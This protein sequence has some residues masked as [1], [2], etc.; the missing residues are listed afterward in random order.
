MTELYTIREVLYQFVVDEK[1][2][3]FIEVRYS[4]TFHSHQTFMLFARL[5]LA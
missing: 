2:E 4:E 3:E 1:D 5:G